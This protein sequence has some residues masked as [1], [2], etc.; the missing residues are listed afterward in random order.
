VISR[1]RKPLGR[2]PLSQ[3][4]PARHKIAAIGHSI[5][6]AAAL[7]ACA[8]DARIVACINLDGDPSFGKFATTGVGKA[9]MVIHQGPVFPE[10]Q[11]DDKLY[12]TG[13][14]LDSKWQEIISKQS[15]PALRLS[16]KGTGHLS[17]TDAIFTRP[18]L[19][20]EGGGV[21]TNPL[22]VLH[23]TTKVILECMQNSFA[24]HPEKALTLPDF[25]GPAKLGSPRG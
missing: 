9:Y 15:A 5:G 11:P 6:G 4:V 7:D 14:D 25:I 1:V 21:W 18:D 12:K 13:R 8:A 19:V 23:G 17:F 22:E 24:G 20:M 10:A 16:V 2:R 3:E